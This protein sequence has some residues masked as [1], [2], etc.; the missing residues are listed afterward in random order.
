MGRIVVTGSQGGLG[1]ALG[2]RLLAAGHSVAGIDRPG[3]SA[4]VEADLTDAAQVRSAVATCA[5]RLGG[6]DG[7]VGAVGI[8][9]TVHRAE[10]FPEAAFRGDVEANLTAQFLVAQAAYEHLSRSAAPAIVFVAS[11]AGLDGLAQQVS[12]AA[13]KAGLIGLTRG[14]A[15]EW[16]PTGIRVNAVAPGLFATPKVRALPE[17]IIARLLT[18]VPLG[19]VAT[20]AEVIGP[21]EFLLSPAAGYMTGQVLRLDGGSGLGVNGIHSGR[22]T[23]GH[24]EAARQLES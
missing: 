1:R 22:S 15:A 16:L 17:Q 10:T 13:S 3:T 14:L 20:L 23:N 8:V 24:R 2:E 7:L 6:I 21:I 4:D 11:L 12:Y 19:R 5:G 9:D 18:T